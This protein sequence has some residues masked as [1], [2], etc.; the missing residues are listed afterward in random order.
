MDKTV[1][2]IGPEDMLSRVALKKFAEGWCDS[3]RVSYIREGLRSS[4]S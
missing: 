3:L 2:E 4:R 1:R